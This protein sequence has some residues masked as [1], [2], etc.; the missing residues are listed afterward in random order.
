MV[1]IFKIMSFGF[2]S[3]GAILIVKMDVRATVGEYLVMSLR[4]KMH[5]LVFSSRPLILAGSLGDCE[6]LSEE[7]GGR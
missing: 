2:I 3:F 6:R 7:E 4:N 1:T 5:F